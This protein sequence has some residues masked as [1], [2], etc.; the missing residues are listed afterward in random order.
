LTPLSEAR[1]ARV[2][3]VL[4]A[5][6][7][8][9]TGPRWWDV[10]QDMLAAGLDVPVVQVHADGAAAA[11]HYAYD[12]AE[13]DRTPVILSIPY[14][15]ATAPATAHLAAPPIE[16]PG[17]PR[18]T[19]EQ[20]AAVAAALRHAE[21]PLLLLGRGAHLA[22]AGELLRRVGDRVGAL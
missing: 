16:R 20:V 7:G 12:L 3:L 10:D 9:S 1:L 5:G 4:L 21:R 15:I 14:D 17:P 22:G 8:P 2:P 11:A 6:E 13:W 18:P 19:G